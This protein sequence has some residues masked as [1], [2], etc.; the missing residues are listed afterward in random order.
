MADCAHLSAVGFRAHLLLGAGS[1]RS[2]LEVGY[3]WLDRRRR[4]LSDPSGGARMEPASPPPGTAPLL[5]QYLAEY[6]ATGLPPAYV[7][8]DTTINDDTDNTDDEEFDT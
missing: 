4:A 6:A 2:E 5:R 8:H 1:K 3:A 7:P